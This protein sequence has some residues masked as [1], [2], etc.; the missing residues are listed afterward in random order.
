MPWVAWMRGMTTLTWPG[1]TGAA[2]ILA[3]EIA[4]ALV[5]AL[6][7]STLATV[8]E[9]RALLVLLLIARIL[10]I[11]IGFARGVV[12]A[13]ALVGL[14]WTIVLAL[15]LLARPVILLRA[16]V[17]ETR[18]LLV[19]LITRIAHWRPLIGSLLALIAAG[20]ALFIARAFIIA[21]AA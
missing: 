21:W 11:A 14:T 20:A 18:G 1:A 10:L 8:V 13:A 7:M 9:T 6:L 16:A 4:L 19:A 17:V 5:V 2:L 12:V 15:L 3:V